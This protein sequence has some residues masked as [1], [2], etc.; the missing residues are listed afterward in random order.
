MTTHTKNEESNVCQL[1]SN[2]SLLSP[3]NIDKWLPYSQMRY[4][5][6]I[7]KL[8][9][10]DPLVQVP[11]HTLPPTILQKFGVPQCVKEDILKNGLC[12]QYITRIESMG[13]SLP[14]HVALHRVTLSAQNGKR[15]Y[16][17]F[18]IT[19]RTPNRFSRQ[20]TFFRG[21]H[22]PLMNRIF[23]PYLAVIRWIEH[24]AT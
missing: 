12:L 11:Q 5:P 15:Q 22:W 14:I 20:Q 2:E 23:E 9:I 16:V 10:L 19:D 4:I 8:G 17:G 6:E 13:Q 7:R 3:S 24:P 21:I 1:Q 18:R